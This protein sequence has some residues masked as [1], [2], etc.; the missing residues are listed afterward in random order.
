LPL[1]LFLFLLAPFHS[2][3]HLPLRFQP[4]LQRVCDEIILPLTELGVSGGIL[5][6]I[7]DAPGERKTKEQPANVQG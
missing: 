7:N 4:W 3:K 2:R 1:L 5:L 6:D